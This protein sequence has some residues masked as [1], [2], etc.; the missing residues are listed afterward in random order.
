MHFLAQILNIVWS[1]LFL[2][3]VFRYGHVGQIIFAI[4]L[5][6]ILIFWFACMIRC[7]SEL[8]IS[9]L[10]LPSLLAKGPRTGAAGGG[11]SANGGVDADLAAYGVGISN[12]AS[13]VV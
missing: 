1:T 12:D 2:L 13:T 10:L 7:L 3:N 5:Y 6:P 4:V 11:H 9:V 8:A